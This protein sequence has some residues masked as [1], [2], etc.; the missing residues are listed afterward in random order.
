MARV[1]VLY[2]S[3][4][5]AA[6]QMEMSTQEDM[7]AGMD[8]RMEWSREVGPALVDFGLPL[9]ESNRI[10]GDSTAAGGS[11]ARGYSIVEA[12]SL[13]SATK[14]LQDHPHLHQPDGWIDVFEMMPMPGM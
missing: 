10:A 8:M 5:S 3:P 9:G 14:M 2:N 11:D 1:L 4:I 7:K 12:E 13:E 6:E